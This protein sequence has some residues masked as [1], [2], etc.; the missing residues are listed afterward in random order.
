MTPGRRPP[1]MTIVRLPNVAMACIDISDGFRADLG[2][3]C[4]SSNVGA[5]IELEKI[6]LSIC[7]Q[8]LIK[9]KKFYWDSVLS[10]GDDYEL[11]FTANRDKRSLIKSFGCQF[12]TLLTRLGSIEHNEGVLILDKVGNEIPT[13]IG[14]WQH[15]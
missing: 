4:S 8:Q 13:K 1:V 14:G 2:H 7:A 15:F 3:I 12:N 5:K 6:P 11:L 9:T 10:G